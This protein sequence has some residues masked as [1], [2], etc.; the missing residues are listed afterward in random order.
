[1][2]ETKIAVFTPTYNRKKY[3]SVLYE[4]LLRQTYKT[5]EWVVVSDGSTDGTDEYMEN[6]IAKSPFL[7]KYLK[8][9]NGGKPSAHNA[10]VEL[11]E[12]EL[13]IICD[14]DDYLTDNALSLVAEFWNKQEDDTIGGLIGYKG[15]DLHT[16]LAN[17][18]FPN[19]RYA[20]LQDLFANKV[21]DT[22][23]IYRTEILKNNKFP[24]IKDEKFMPEMWLWRKIDEKYKLIVI[25]E[26]LEICEY[27]EGG[28]TKGGTQTMWNNPKGYSYY[29]RQRYEQTKGLA[30]IKYCGIYRGLRRAAKYKV[31]DSCIFLH[32]ILCLPVEL[33][34]C[35]RIKIYMKNIVI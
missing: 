21:F 6:L 25:P 12:S 24:D 28:L 23:Q 3:L 19:C 8:K 18:H 32:K 9:E 5:F 31:N 2:K 35:L 22:T 29:F 33:Y 11:A 27:L 17:M 15:S 26:I 16:P 10:G 34:V 7:I 13:I 30:Q 20:N 4:S 14:D 1:M